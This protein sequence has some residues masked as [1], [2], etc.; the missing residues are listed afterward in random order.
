MMR[1][2]SDYFKYRLILLLSITLLVVSSCS[3]TSDFKIDLV[4]AKATYDATASIT[5]I[6][7]WIQLEND[8]GKKANVKDWSF[9]IKRGNEV[10]LVINKDNYQEVLGDGVYYFTHYDFTENG[11]IYL[12]NWSQSYCKPYFGD[13]FKGKNP[14]KVEVT[15]EIKN[16]SEYRISG[17]YPFTMD[18]N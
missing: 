3:L 15:V 13:L 11:S 4:E 18:R 5:T 7:L 1:A 6:G 2:G 9:T 14:D 10:L 8:N 16:G 17:N 12:D